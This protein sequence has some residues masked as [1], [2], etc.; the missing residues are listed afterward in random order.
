V[1]SGTS[2]EGFLVFECFGTASI[3]CGAGSMKRYVCLS[4][5]PSIYLSVP[6]WAH[7]SKPTAAGLRLWAWQAVDID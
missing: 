7:S 5:C 2:S 4:V 6:A 1:V 3:V